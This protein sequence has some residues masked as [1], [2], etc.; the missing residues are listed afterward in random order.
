MTK[1][2]TAAFIGC[3]VEEMDRDHDDIHRGL[4][5]LL[6]VKSYS[7]AVANR[8]QLTHEEWEIANYEEDAVLYVQRW[9]RK[10][11]ENSN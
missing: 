2:E 3:S 11:D 1:E 9:L 8:E 6:D 5:K 10:Y 4:C 7:M